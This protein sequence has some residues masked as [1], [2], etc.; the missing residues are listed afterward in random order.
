[1]KILGSLY[2]SSSSQSKRDIAKN[3]LK[4]VT[5]QFPDDVEAWIELAQILEQ[6]DIL[7]SLQAYGTATKILKEKVQENIPPEILNNVGALHYRLNNLD[8]AK[9][10][11]EES[12]ALSKTEAEHDPHYYNSIAVTTTY[13]LAR[14]NE[15]LCQFDKSEK[16]YKDIIKEHPNY[17]DCY[18]RLGCMARDKGQ[19]YDASYMFKEALRINNKHPDAWSLIG[20]LHLVK[21]EMGPG[22][23]KFERILSNASTSQDPYSLTALGNVWL[24]MLHLPAKHKEMDKK[25]QDRALSHYKLVLRNDQKNIWATNGIGAVLAH[26]G[27]IN[28]ARDIFAQVRESTAD[29]CD[30]WM[31]IAHIYV[32]QRQYV[33]AIQMVS[34]S[35]N[36]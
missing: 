33:S 19:I 22:Q 4:K 13:N 29:F 3:H 6:S 34:S 20:N 32:E 26:K 7:L 11:L 36:L 25:H 21:Y 2:A 14:L 17:V 23:K 27:C 8:E 28:E 15:A 9:K 5:E 18:L 10:N 1:M 16:L 31:N 12:L 35:C 30:V 24:Q